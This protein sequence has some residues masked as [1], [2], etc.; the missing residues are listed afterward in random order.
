MLHF[1]KELARD[2]GE[3][4]LERWD[5]LRTVS[6]KDTAIDL[7]T[8]ADRAAEDFLVKAIQKRYP[9]HQIFGEEGTGGPE[10]LDH[11][12]YVWILDPLDGTVNYAHH[13]P[14][15]AV[16]IGILK[17]GEPEFAV[18]FLP[19][20]GELFSAAKGQ[21]AYLNDKPIQVSK[22]SE[23]KDCL[24]ATGFP[25][26]K[27]ESEVDNL[28]N[29]SHFMKQARGIRRLGSAAGDLVFVACGRFDGYWEEKLQPWDVAAGILIVKEAGGKVTGYDGKKACLRVGRFVA[30]NNQIHDKLL[31]PLAL[32][33]EKHH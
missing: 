32:Y 2:C 17:D 12:G 22:H 24:L 15:F 6:F 29:F 19:A 1:A 18:V 7:V 8:D 5:Q 28:S 16:S 25:Y 30:T 23:L 14:M 13:I 33:A 31:E 26:D 4:L 20:L 3:L 10:L 27:H 11:D 21:G 9:D